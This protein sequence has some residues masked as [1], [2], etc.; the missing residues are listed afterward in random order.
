[1]SWFKEKLILLSL[2]SKDRSWLNVNERML[3]RGPE[4]IDRFIYEKNDKLIGFVDLSIYKNDSVAMA[5]AVNSIFQGKGYS[6]FLINHA[7]K[8]AKELQYKYLLYLVD[9]EN[10]KSLNAIKKHKYFYKYWE[11][12]F[13]LHYICELDLI[14][15]SNL[16]L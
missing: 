2:S 14:N 16:Q 13:D 5:Y 15:I 9:K 3:Q 1:M 7:I 11:T 10:I 8:R 12:K 4:V 6:Q